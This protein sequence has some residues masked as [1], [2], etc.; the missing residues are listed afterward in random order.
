MNRLLVQNDQV[1]FFRS[2]VFKRQEYFGTVGAVRFI[3]GRRLT[4][5]ELRA[6]RDPIKVA[7]ATLIGY[8]GSTSPNPAD[9]VRAMFI[10]LSKNNKI[11]EQGTISELQLANL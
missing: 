6:F 9:W 5:G 11:H 1:R 10:V 2:K 4:P 7:R 3:P 8:E